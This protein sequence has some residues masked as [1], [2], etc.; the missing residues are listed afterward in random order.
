MP[1][2]PVQTA[3]QPVVIGRLTAVHGVKGWIKVHSF[4]EPVENF[5][6]YTKCYIQRQGQWQPVEF[7]ATQ[8]HGKGILAKLRGV[9]NPEAARLYSGTDVAVAASEL[10]TLAADDFYWRDLEG[11]QVWVQHPERG[12]LRLGRVDHLLETG[13]NDVLVVKGDD[14]SIDQRERLIPYLPELVVKAVDLAAGTLEVDWDPD[15]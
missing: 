15:F 10:P 11:L 4:T 7:E 3:L 8:R 1:D 14:G 2:A 5:L 13:A 12:L 9:E 6:S